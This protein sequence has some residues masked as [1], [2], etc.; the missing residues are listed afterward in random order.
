MAIT[1]KR[2]DLIAVTLND[3]AEK[4]LP[5]CG[6]LNLEDAETGQMRVIDSSARAVREKY[7]KAAIERAG[8]RNLLFHSLGVDHISVATDLPYTKELVKFFIQRRRRRF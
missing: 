3:P 4:E 1:N 6:L 7:R 5:S 2:H 8:K